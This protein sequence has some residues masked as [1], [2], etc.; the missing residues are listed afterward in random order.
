MTVRTQST[1]SSALPDPILQKAQQLERDG[2]PAEA[3]LAYR[4]ILARDPHDPVALHLL[5]MLCFRTG[6]RFEGLDFVR[7]SL[8]A[9]PDN[10]TFHANYAIPL[11]TSGRF[12][13]AIVAIQRAIA[14]R[15][16]H[17]PSHNNLG[18][19]LEKA[20]RF[21]EAVAALFLP[22]DNP[23]FGEIVGGKLY[24]HA[25]AGEDADEMLAH[26]AGDNAEDFGFGI[27][28]LELEHRVGERGDDGRFNFNRLGFGHFSFFVQNQLSDQNDILPGYWRAYNPS[29]AYSGSDS[30][31]RW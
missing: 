18:V 17:A 1:S 23:P 16:S 24:L 27:V 28:E 4:R 9:S 22:E 31:M 21:D 11:G 15:P 12:E 7:R 2:K 25:V 14:L 10:P 20:G 3:E 5:G 30:R 26:F 13:E 29:Q 8:L 6:R 19:T